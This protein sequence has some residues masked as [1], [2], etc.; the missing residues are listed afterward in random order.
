M[1][2]ME[3][4]LMMYWLQWA[5]EMSTQHQ[6]TFPC[7]E[8]DNYNLWHIDFDDH[9]KYQYKLKCFFLATNMTNDIGAAL[10]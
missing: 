1:A 6:L 2:N 10:I 8:C 7:D 9:V 5:Y 4:F 3:T